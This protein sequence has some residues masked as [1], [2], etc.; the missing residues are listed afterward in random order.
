MIELKIK[1]PNLDVLMRHGYDSY[2]QIE[3]LKKLFMKILR[4]DMFDLRIIEI[5]MEFMVNVLKEEDCVDYIS[6][7]SKNKWLT[8]SKDL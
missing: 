6:R 5:Y 8:S 1:K 2:K 7:V 4:S 3:D